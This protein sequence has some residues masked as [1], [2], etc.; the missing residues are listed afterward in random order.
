MKRVDREN[1]IVEF[2][3]DE[4]MD[5]SFRLDGCQVVKHD[6][7]DWLGEGREWIPQDWKY[8]AMVEQASAI[9][10]STKEQ[11]PA[12]KKPHSHKPEQLALI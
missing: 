11:K 2:E 8:A 1:K 12:V 9:L 5:M 3:T 4:A 10:K 6:V 7:T